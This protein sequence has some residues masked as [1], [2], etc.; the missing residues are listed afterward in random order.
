MNPMQ[1]NLNPN[2]LAGVRGIINTLKTAGNPQMLLQQM[3][4]QNPMVAQ[5]LQIVRDYGGNPQ[6]AFYAKAK[7]L[8]VDPNAVLSQLR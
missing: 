8:G 1:Q 5:V 2:N 6:T 4:A 7:E 3:S